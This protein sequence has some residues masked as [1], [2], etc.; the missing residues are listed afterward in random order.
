MTDATA[1]AALIE[2]VEG[3]KGPCDWDIHQNQVFTDNDQL[4]LFTEA[5]KGSL[6]ATVRFVEEVLP[7]WE[8]MLSFGQMPA[9]AVVSNFK[10]DIRHGADAPTPA[11]ALVLAALRALASQQPKGV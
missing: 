5:V 7:G 8:V 3:L 4:W 10:A 6:D 9:G 1:V 11:L 2:K